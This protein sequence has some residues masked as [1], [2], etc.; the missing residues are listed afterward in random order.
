M[1]GSQQSVHIGKANPAWGDLD[2]FGILR[3]HDAQQRPMGGG[4]A[5]CDAADNAGSTRQNTRRPLN[6]LGWDGLL[7]LA[8][9]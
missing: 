2:F 9:I 5:D 4:F 3:E 8:L 1:K 6:N 7:N